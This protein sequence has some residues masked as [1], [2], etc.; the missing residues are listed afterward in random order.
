MGAKVTRAARKSDKPPP[1]G[2]VC[3]GPRRIRAAARSFSRVPHS[4]RPA[5]CQGVRWLARR[6][7]RGFRP[8]DHGCEVSDSVGWLRPIKWRAYCSAH[9]SASPLSTRAG[10]TRAI[11]VQPWRP[12]KTERGSP[13][14]PASSSAAGR[15]GTD[16]PE[17][18][19]AQRRRSWNTAFAAAPSVRVRV[20]HLARDLAVAVHVRP[21]CPAARDRRLPQTQDPGLLGVP[22]AD[23]LR[24]V[25][26]PQDPADRGRGSGDRAGTAAGSP[27]AGRGR[28]DVF[29]CGARSGD[30]V[31]GRPAAPLAQKPSAARVRPARTTE[32]A[33]AKSRPPIP[34]SRTPGSGRI[35]VPLLPMERGTTP[36]LPS[37][38][39]ERALPASACS[40]AARPR[41][42]PLGTPRSSSTRS[43]EIT[44]RT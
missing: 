15:S 11:T 30:P 13:P 24:V 37:G 40:G 3:G 23:V 27:S 42:F 38:E 41:D 4:Q 26:Q 33:A 29:A 18:E 16:R 5:R 10:R 25:A 20:H 1:F 31:A 8:A 12:G 14:G 17:R 44:P 7:R 9:P 39:E 34:P 35:R 32:K 28:G 21:S 2:T 22:R 43:R 6:C 19:G 36:A